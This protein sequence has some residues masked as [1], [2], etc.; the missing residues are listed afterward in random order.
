MSGTRVC[1]ARI[2][3]P[4]GVRGEVRLWVFTEDAAAIKDYGPLESEDGSQLFEIE[5]LRPGKRFFVA[6]LRGIADRAAAERLNNVDLYVPR[7]KLPPPD[8][9]ETF[10]HADLIGMTAVDRQG[11]TIGTVLAVQNFGAGDLLEIQPA[12]G[13]AA[14]L[15]P[16]TKAAVPMV[17]VAARR[18]VVDPPDG[19]FED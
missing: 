10:Y 9:A 17:D 5:S 15:L 4:H 11:E 13:G 3:A 8:D 14:A 2:G 18:I 16:F 7:E 6:R 12:G 19:T 1:V